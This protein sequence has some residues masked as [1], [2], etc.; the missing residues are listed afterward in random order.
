[1]QPQLLPAPGRA[2]HTRRHTRRRR[3][4]RAVGSEAVHEVAQRVVCGAWTPPPARPQPRR[5]RPACHA[6]RARAVQ[7]ACRRGQRHNKPVLLM[8]RED[9]TQRPPL[10]T[11]QDS[12]CSN[13]ARGDLVH[14]VRWPGDRLG[15]SL[16][17]TWACA[18]VAHHTCPP[19]PPPKNT[20]THRGPG[21]APA[22][23]SSAACV[24]S[25][26]KVTRPA[27]PRPLPLARGRRHRPRHQQHWPLRSRQG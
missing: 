5:S 25:A 19:P 3:R 2:A 13:A 10:L 14:G 11:C 17:D 26:S 22:V 15:F 1:M 23:C 4:C 6:W 7:A 16:H 18:A 20:L 12:E 27:L 8:T 21:P 24:P 9:Q